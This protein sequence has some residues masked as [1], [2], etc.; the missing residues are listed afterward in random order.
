[1]KKN[2]QVICLSLMLILLAGIGIV[3]AAGVQINWDYDSSYDDSTYLVSHNGY[4]WYLGG[5]Y[6]NTNLNS[7]SSSS[8]LGV[9]A[10]LTGTLTSNSE[11][12]TVYGTAGGSHLVDGVSNTVFAEVTQTGNN[13]YFE[14]VTQT[15]SSG[16]ERSFSVEANSEVTVTAELADFEDLI[17]WTL[18][19]SGVNNTSYNISATVNVMPDGEAA[20]QSL[21]VLRSISL[22]DFVDG[23]GTIVFNPV[24]GVDFYRLSTNLILETEL[25][26]VDSAGPT[27]GTALDVG[28]IG[29][30]TLNTMVSANAVP[31]PG[32]I[33]LLLSGFAGLAALL[34]RSKY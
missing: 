10:D 32:S 15:I 4:L 17:N 11:T 34:R 7:T 33:I 14:G 23:V 3:Q 22:D 13:I 6:P 31:V 24:A 26:N 16:V 20:A 30:L 9:S 12:T 1:M 25:A 21:D 29:E 19:A 28:S 27:I 5:S 8:E 2:L 18:V